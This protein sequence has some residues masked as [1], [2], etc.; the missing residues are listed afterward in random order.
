MF[1]YIAGNTFLCIADNIHF[2]VLLAIH[3]Y[4]M[5]TICFYVL[6]VI[7]LLCIAGNMFLYIVG[8]IFSMYVLC[9]SSNMFFKHSWQYVSLF[10]DVLLLL[11]FTLK[12]YY[13]EFCYEYR[14]LDF[15][16]VLTFVQGLIICP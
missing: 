15:N 4:V 13:A 12:M 16:R 1:L 14:F 2:C 11:L 8:N 5:L 9:I 7:R 10:L 3:C 6:L